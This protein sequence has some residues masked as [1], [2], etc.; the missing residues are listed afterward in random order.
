MPKCVQKTD[1]QFEYFRVPSHYRFS[2]Y[3]IYRN[4]ED[5]YGSSLA[6]KQE[7]IGNAEPNT[8]VVIEGDRWVFYSSAEFERKFVTAS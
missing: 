2:L 7:H 4:R 8:Y 1:K 5:D 3:K 6:D